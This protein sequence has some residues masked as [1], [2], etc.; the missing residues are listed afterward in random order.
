MFKFFNKSNNDLDISP[1]MSYP[2]II[3]NESSKDHACVSIKTNRG[4]EK[5]KFE[6]FVR[7]TWN[8]KVEITCDHCITVSK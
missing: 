4:T 5:R 2:G 6:R 1:L 8:G 3:I 7:E